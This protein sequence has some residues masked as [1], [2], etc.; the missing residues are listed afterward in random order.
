[1]PIAPVLVFRC[2]LSRNPGAKENKEIHS[3]I[4]IGYICTPLLYVAER[5]TLRRLRLQHLPRPAL[6]LLWRIDGLF[7]SIE[8][9][10]R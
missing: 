3:A 1:M 8:I 5:A 10:V 4:S 2:V 9:T 6:S 7:R